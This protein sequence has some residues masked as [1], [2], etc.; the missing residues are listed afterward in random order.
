MNRKKEQRKNSVF[1]EPPRLFRAFHRAK[2]LHFA[3]GQE[4]SPFPLPPLFPGQN[5]IDALQKMRT[6]SSS[7]LRH[8]VYAARQ[9]SAIVSAAY[10]PTTQGNV[11]ILFCS[12]FQK[13]VL[14]DKALSCL[15][16]NRKND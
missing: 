11:R 13:E 14:N 7:P 3:R 9:T 8:P 16:Q 5:R 2:I 4:G 10:I 6:M 12:K 1:I 15:S